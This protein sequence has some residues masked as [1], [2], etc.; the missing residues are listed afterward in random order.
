MGRKK[1][2][3]IGTDAWQGAYMAWLTLP[4][5]GMLKVP[6]TLP[7]LEGL[8]MIGQWTAPPG[9]LPSALLSSRWAVQR[10][11]QKNGKKFTAQNPK[12]GVL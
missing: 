1:M 2:L 4:E 3:I 11:C 9:G 8:Y 6:N 5:N 12:L 7:N 10:I